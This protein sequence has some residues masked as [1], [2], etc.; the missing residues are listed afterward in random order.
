MRLRGVKSVLL[1]VVLAGSLLLPVAPVSAAQSGKVCKKVGATSTDKSRGKTVKLICAKVGKKLLWVALTETVGQR[2]ARKT[3]Q[4]YLRSSS[5]SRSELILLLWYVGGFTQSEAEYAADAAGLWTTVAPTTTVPRTTTVATTTTLPRTTTTTT[6]ALIE[7]VSQ[8]NARRSAQSYLNIMA[9][10]RTGLI[11][12]LEFEGYS[13]LDATYGVDA[14]NANWNNQAKKSAQ[15]YLDI[16]AFSRTGLIKQLE[17]EG[18]ST[19]E[20]AYGVDAL[21]TNWNEQAKKSA[22]SYLDNSSFSRSGLIDQLLY[23]GFTQGQAEY[24]VNSVGL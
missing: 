7:T 23:E 1:V 12:Q 21:N 8:R 6:V 10:S 24:G 14:Q 3:A 18:Y 15:S 22:Q 13:T 9:F 4:S 17:F 19:S 20:A 16:M 2:N 11:K 5:F